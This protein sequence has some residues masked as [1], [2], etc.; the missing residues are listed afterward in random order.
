M[1]AHRGYLSDKFAYNER[2]K[3]TPVKTVY[4]DANL[5]SLP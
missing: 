5:V 1:V 2:R 3:M 4:V